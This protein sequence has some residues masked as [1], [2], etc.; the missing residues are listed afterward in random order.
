MSDQKVPGLGSKGVGGK[1]P[2]LGNLRSG[3][4]TDLPKR[5]RGGGLFDPTSGEPNK[6]VENRNKI[7]GGSSQCYTLFYAI[8]EIAVMFLPHQSLYC[9]NHQPL[10]DNQGSKY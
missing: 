4:R 1:I 9:F 7:L 10:F 5:K 8:C 6:I 2:L 3:I